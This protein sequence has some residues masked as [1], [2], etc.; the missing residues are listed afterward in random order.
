M[1]TI[2]E[3]KTDD[4]AGPIEKLL[5]CIEAKKLE[6]TRV[7][8]SAVTADFI[9]YIESIQETAQ[10]YVIADFLVVAAKLMLLKSKELLPS[11]TLTEEEESEIQDLETRL[12]IY[13]AFKARSVDLQALWRVFPQMYSRPLF[14]HLGNNIVFYPPQKVSAESLRTALTAVLKT[15]EETFAEPQKV[16]SRIVRIEEKIQE[17]MLRLQAGGGRMSDW[18][19]HKPRGEVIAIFL[20]ILHLF[21]SSM[22]HVEQE[23]VFG[24]ILFKKRETHT[25]RRNESKQENPN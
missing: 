6:V 4:F 11:L 24:D 1:T 9:H 12:Q 14:F 3:I 25:A 8:L 5:E 18:A 20:A 22:I 7:S 2:F 10:P 23:G 16:K 21:K 15:L 13:R 19:R 17:I